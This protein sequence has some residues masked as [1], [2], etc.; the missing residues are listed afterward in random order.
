MIRPFS[1]GRP[2]EVIPAIDLFDGKTV[3]LRQG[4]YDEVTV[5]SD[6][7]VAVA[8][9]WRGQVRRIHVVDLEGARAGKTVAREL[10]ERIVGAFGPGVEVG[11]GIRSFEAVERAFELGVERVVLGTAAVRDPALVRRAALAY[12]N[13]VVVAVD[14]RGGQVAT[15]GWEQ[16]STRLAIELVGEL[17]ELPLAAVLYADIEPDGTQV[18]PN[19]EETARQAE[20]TPTSGIGRGR[21]PAHQS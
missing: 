1:T 19:L 3:R 17:A 6:D 14:A 5:Y 10:V 8:A 7:P 18:G 12:P 9:S 16:T 11:G 15:D 13:R 21:A 4:R 20:S 2:M